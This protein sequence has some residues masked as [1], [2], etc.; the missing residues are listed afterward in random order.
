MYAQPVQVQPQYS[1]PQ[2]GDNPPYV[3]L[4]LCL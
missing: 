2:Y 4:S 1:Q 3:P